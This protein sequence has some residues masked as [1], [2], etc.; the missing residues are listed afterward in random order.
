LLLVRAEHLEERQDQ[1]DRNLAVYVV[2]QF[3]KAINRGSK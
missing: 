2:D 3:V 1:R